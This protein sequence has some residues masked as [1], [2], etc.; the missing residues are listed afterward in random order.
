MNSRTA[1]MSSVATEI[2]TGFTCRKLP[3]N[4]V[5]RQRLP[6]LHY[7]VHRAFLSRE[8]PEAHTSNARAQCRCHRTSGAGRGL[9]ELAI[10]ENV[11]GTPGR[12]SIPPLRSAPPASA[13]APRVSLSWSLKMD[14][15]RNRRD[16]G[17]GALLTAH[18]ASDR[19]LM[20][21]KGERVADATPGKMKRIACLLV[22]GCKAR[23]ALSPASSGQSPPSDKRTPCPSCSP[24]AAINDPI[25]KCH[26]RNG[27]ACSDAGPERAS[28][29]AQLSEQGRSHVMR[30][31]SL[32][33]TK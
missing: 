33:H 20:A 18:S 19:P 7:S 17:L 10:C 9:A 11:N 5:G 26:R 28:V 14:T 32:G 29:S 25:R 12:P 3:G 13:S 24:A 1:A 30:F 22:R 27:Q 31:L 6:P 15:R 23:T 16:G 2:P 8:A 4:P 21:I